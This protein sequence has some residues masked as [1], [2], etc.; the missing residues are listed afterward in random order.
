MKSDSRTIRRTAN[1]IDSP[2]T[3]ND[4]GDIGNGSSMESPF[5]GYSSYSRLQSDLGES[6][7]ILSTANTMAGIRDQ[8]VCI[9][10][11]MVNIAN[12]LLLT[13]IFN[14]E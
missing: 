2:A 6:F 9:M 1:I 14:D 13:V 3:T 7:M 5:A 8:Q 12:Q 11:L 10:I 4:K